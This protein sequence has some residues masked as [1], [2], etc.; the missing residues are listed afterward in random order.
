MSSCKCLDVVYANPTLEQKSLGLLTTFLR[1]N[2]KIVKIV[3]LI[4]ESSYM[5]GIRKIQPRAFQAPD[6]TSST[7]PIDDLATLITIPSRIPGLDIALEIKDLQKSCN[8]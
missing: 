1:A 2:D 3:N 8:A 5:Y 4:P 6:Q 7:Y